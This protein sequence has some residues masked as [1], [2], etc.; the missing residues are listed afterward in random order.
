MAYFDSL[1]DA[2]GKSFLLLFFKKEVLPLRAGAALFLT[3]CLGGS[4]GRVNVPRN[5][6]YIW[7]RRWTPALQG[8]IAANSDLFQSWHILAAEISADG[9]AHTVHVNW[10]WMPASS[11]AAVPVVRIE[12]RIT[13]ARMPGIIAE[14]VA[15]VAGAP[16][17]ARGRLEIDHDC[18]TAH[19]ADYAAF[20]R[21]LREAIGPRT[22][23]T[24]TALPTWLA[25]ADFAAV[26]DAADLLVL[27]VHAIED[28]RLGLFDPG[29]AAR[30]VFALARRT[31]RPFLVALPAYGARV[32]ATVE[33]RLLAVSAEMPAMDGETGEEVVASPEAVASFLQAMRLDRPAQMRGVVWFRLP[34]VDDRRAWNGATLRAVVRGDPLRPHID[35]VTRPGIV[36]GVAD[37]LVENSGDEDGA[38]PTEVALPGGCEVFDGVGQYG[39]DGGTLML[40]GQG[41]VPPHASVLAGWMRCG[42]AGNLHAAD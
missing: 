29:R 35:I 15:V 17:L 9:S 8:A 26:A 39:I 1:L 33:G 12:G 21:A 20:L 3:L 14:I 28:P 37:I 41:L 22:V 34:T 25:A 13:P 27:Q 32:A 30:W 5:D 7:Q 38:L 11:L 16:A 4:A 24:V 6:V 40:R 36:P 18:A 31:S 10:S 2:I 42:D 23:I 19:L